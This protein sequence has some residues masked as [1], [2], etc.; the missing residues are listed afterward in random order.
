[1]KRERE[2]RQ[3]GQTNPMLL[4][5]TIQNRQSITLTQKQERLKYNTVLT[6]SALK[7]R[8]RKKALVLDASWA[9][10]GNFERSFSQHCRV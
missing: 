6:A 4:D 5:C 9:V 8:T 7:Q 1:M 2:W 3:A 10:E